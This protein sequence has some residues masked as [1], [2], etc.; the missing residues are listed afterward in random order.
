MLPAGGP[1]GSPVDDEGESEGPV[2]T[3][4]E[5]N[6]IKRTGT[7]GG[8]AS[9]MC[10]WDIPLRSGLL[11]VEVLFENYVKIKNEYCAQLKDEDARL[12]VGL[13]EQLGDNGIFSSDG[14]FENSVLK[15]IDEQVFVTVPGCLN[16][17]V[18]GMLRALCL[19][20]TR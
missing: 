10:K 3:A 11:N 14:G 8:G 1:G 2:A 5:A 13:M 6:D 7:G 9:M 12:K 16:G 15:L 17:G 4:G 20:K 18:S 19:E